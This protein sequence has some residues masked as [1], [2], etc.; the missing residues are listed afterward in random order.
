MNKTRIINELSLHFYGSKGWMRSDNCECPN[1]KKSDKF[2]IL[3]L[4][5]GGVVKCMRCENSTSLFNYL[6]S[7]NRSELI[8]GFS[9]PI[10][11]TLKL[12]NNPEEVV[13]VKVGEVKLPTGFKRLYFDD[14]LDNRGFTTFQYNLFRA[15]KSK[16]LR[17]KNHIVFP[18][19]KDGN[20]VTWLAR[21]RKSKEWHKE[22]IKYFK[23]GV[24]RLVLRYYNADGTDFEDI[25]G[26][27]DEVVQDRT[28]TV[29]LVEGL[30]DK[31]NIDRLL[32]L[33]ESDSV[34]CCFTFGKNLSK[35]QV[36]LMKIK[37]VKS[38]ILLYDPDALDTIQKFSLK[39]MNLF[40]SVKCARLN[41]VNP[42][43]DL[44]DPGDL[45]IE[46]IS[47]IMKNLFSPVDFYFNNLKKIQN[48]V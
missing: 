29:I 33:Y 6:V 11:E 48:H 40:D 5:G 1:C 23:Q 38:I 10:Q 34:K 4:Q 32:N 47:E 12:I 24:G 42:G 17:L 30:F 43:G 7:I 20:L 21:S 13:K 18:I 27:Y 41:F 16:D 31:S 35:T 26:G 37:G 8:E 46:E 28:N 36:E 44:K 2:G 25:I 14:Y 39:Y 19:Y 3:F 9:A 45:N 15:G 22:N